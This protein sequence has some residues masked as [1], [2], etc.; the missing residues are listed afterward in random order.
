MKLRTGMV[1]LLV[2]AVAI[3]GTAMAQRR[4]VRTDN[5]GAICD[6]QHWSGLY[7][8]PYMLV[9]GNIDGKYKLSTFM[10]PGTVTT[11][12]TIHVCSPRPLLSKIW[13]TFDP[14]QP[15]NPASQPDDTG[16]PTNVALTA[17][18]AIMYEWVNEGASPPLEFLQPPDVEVIVWTLPTSTQLPDGAYE[19]ELDNWCGLSPYYTEGTQVAPHT[20]SSFNWGDFSYSAACAGFT[21]NTSATD[22]VLNSSGALIGYLDASNTLHFSSTAPGWTIT[23]R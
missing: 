15:P 23:A 5:P 7:E 1:L 19:L 11:G 16:Q 12:D 22:L 20:N 21:A 14:G 3:P 18:G 8:D 13:A 2:A 9:N 6:M 17:R 4:G 10:K